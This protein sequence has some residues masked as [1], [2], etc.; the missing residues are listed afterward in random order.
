M[1]AACDPGVARQHNEDAVYLGDNE[2]HGYYLAMVCDGMG[3]HNAGEIASAI[4]IECIPRFIRDNFSEQSPEA[5]LDAAFR[6]ASAQI[7]EHAAANPIAKGMG[8]TCVLLLGLDAKIYFAHSG[9]SRAYRS[10]GTQLT[11]MTVDHTMIQEM[12]DKGLLSPEQAAIHPYR[13]RI[14]RCLGHGKN[15]DEPTV[16]QSTF[17]VGDSLLLCSDGLS[18][19]VNEADIRA[20]MEQRDVRS[21][22]RRL[23]DAANTAGGPDNVSAILL[24]R[25]G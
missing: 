10:R 15:R 5:L 14:S 9:D 21:G 11:P 2:Q 1:A 20:L 13:G 24:R 25:P 6:E 3:G 18:D 17:A 7:D 16:T 8:C 22:S 4:A 19:V 23:I 12:L